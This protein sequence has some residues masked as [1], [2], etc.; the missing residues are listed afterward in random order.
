MNTM[1][2]VNSLASGTGLAFVG[3]LA[4]A[5]AFLLWFFVAVAREQSHQR[6]RYQLYLTFAN[7][8]VETAR[9]QRWKRAGK[10]P[11][12]GPRAPIRLLNAGMLSAG[13]LGSL[14]P[15]AELGNGGGKKLR[16]KPAETGGRISLSQPGQP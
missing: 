7:P 14:A 9:A 5:V 2:G 8:A 4:A 6:A 12:E 11:L 1:M 10:V 16:R 15:S 13:M 3:L